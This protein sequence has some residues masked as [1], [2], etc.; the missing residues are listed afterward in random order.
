MTRQRKLA[1]LGGG[2]S[3]LAAAHG[4]LKRVNR[5]G[6]PKNSWSVD[7]FDSSSRPGGWISTQKR[8]VLFEGGPRTLRPRGGPE[9]QAMLSLI[10][11]L[12]LADEIITTP[13][14]SPAAKNRFI[15]DGKRLNRLPPQ[16]KTMLLTPWQVPKAVYAFALGVLK[17][18]F[19]A[20]RTVDDESVHEFVARRL[21][22]ERVATDIVSA[23]MHGIYAGDARKL[24]ARSTLGSLWEME[25]SHGSIVRAGIASMLGSKSTSMSSQESEFGEI[26]PAVTKVLSDASVFSFKNGA[27]TLVDA[28]HQ[29]LERSGVRIHQGEPCLS[30]QSAASGSE[31]IRIETSS[32]RTLDADAV[33]TA[34]PGPQLAKL[35]THCQHSEQYT[36]LLTF[37]PAVDVAVVCLAFEN[38]KLPVSGFGYL[39]PS[40]VLAASQ[41]AALGVVFDSDAF[42]DPNAPTIT[43]VTVMMGGYEF[44]RIL[45]DSIPDEQLLQHALSTLRDHLGIAATPIAHSVRVNRQCISQY[46]VGHAD[47]VKNLEALTEEEF[48]SRLKMAGA[49]LYGVSVG[50]CIASGLRAAHSVKVG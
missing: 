26:D 49:S 32:G 50:N 1:V 8:T 21:G 6:L 41:T 10:S 23:V 34:L 18:P 47:R 11:D 22:S 3:G 46:L 5:L 9:V 20:K 39:I 38:V 4:F 36:Q 13:K 16:L 2:I 42:P 29:S 19:I 48:G 12:K 35:L 30:I 25:S 17:E 45:G 33:I 27:Q 28:L 7:I 43:R 24:S 40:P 14:S 37:N 31:P 44:K 15:Y